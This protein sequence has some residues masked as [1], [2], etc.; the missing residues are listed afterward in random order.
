MTNICH[1]TVFDTLR[2][3]RERAESRGELARVAATTET[4]RKLA[5]PKRPPGKIPAGAASVGRDARSKSA[6]VP[7]D[8]A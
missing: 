4:E 3:V 5:T 2:V 6:T 1:N 7:A 8:D